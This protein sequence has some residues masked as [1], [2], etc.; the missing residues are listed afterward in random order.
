MSSLERFT[1][2]HGT[3]KLELIVVID[4]V[5]RPFCLLSL[6]CF[7]SSLFLLSSGLF[8]LHTLRRKLGYEHKETSTGRA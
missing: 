5:C 4:N 2:G 1:V 8:T 7:H 3:V 6:L